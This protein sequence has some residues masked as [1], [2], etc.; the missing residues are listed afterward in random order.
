VVMELLLYLETAMPNAPLQE[1]CTRHEI[2]LHF[3]YYDWQVREEGAWVDLGC[4]VEGCNQP[5]TLH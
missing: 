1:S 2:C 5:Y 4:R 3:K